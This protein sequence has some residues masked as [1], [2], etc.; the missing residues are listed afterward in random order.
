MRRKG[1][2]PFFLLYLRIALGDYWFNQCFFFYLI[3][4]GHYNFCPILALFWPPFI[5]V[6]HW[7]LYCFIVISAY[8][9]QLEGVESRLKKE[10]QL[11]DE[12]C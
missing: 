11:W 7:V 5:C 8:F 12:Y 2:N 9:N 1:K 3:C 4:P 6:Y 10:I